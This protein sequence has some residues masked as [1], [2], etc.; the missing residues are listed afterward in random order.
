MERGDINNI[1]EGWLLQNNQENLA[2][3]DMKGFYNYPTST[4]TI[5]NLLNNYKTMMC[6]RPRSK[7]Y[8]KQI[9]FSKDT[10][11]EKQ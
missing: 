3:N 5:V 1:V 9:P 11:R 4:K 7:E 8:E 2:N 10:R 6:F